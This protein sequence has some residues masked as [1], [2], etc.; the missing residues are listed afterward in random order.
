MPVPIST[1]T[2]YGSNSDI[3]QSGIVASCEGRRYAELGVAIHAARFLACR[4]CVRVEAL[5]LAGESGLIF[6]RDQSG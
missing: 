4:G 5:D 6:G 1:P 2:R 3:G